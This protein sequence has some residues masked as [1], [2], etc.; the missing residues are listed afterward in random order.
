MSGANSYSCAG[1]DVRVIPG[2]ALF[3][4]CATPDQAVKVASTL[5]MLSSRLL[6][7]KTLPGPGGWFKVEDA[8][9][10]VGEEVTVTDGVGIWTSRL[11][12]SVN[13]NTYLPGCSQPVRWMRLDATGTPQGEKP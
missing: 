11:T 1:C 10:G 13:W 3:C 2:G 4:E 8:M 6:G 5:N 9:P 12:H 7:P